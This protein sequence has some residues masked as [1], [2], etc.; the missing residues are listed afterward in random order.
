MQSIM[1]LT[2]PLIGLAFFALSGQGVAASKSDQAKEKRWE[3]QIVPSLLVGEAVKLKAADVEFLGLYTENDTD[4]A[5]GGVILLHGMGAHPAWPSIIDPLR[6][7][8][9]ESGWHTLSLQM[10]ILK[11]E[12]VYKDY[13]P[14]FDE[15]PVRIQAG[16]DYLKAK[17]INNI[18]IIGHSL[19]NTMTTN[20]LATKKDPSVRAFVAIAL[21]P[22][23]PKDPR[24]D[25]YTNF[26]KVTIPTLDIYGSSDS[27]RIIKNARKRKKVAKKAGNKEYQQVKVEGANHFF[28]SMEDVLLQRI[29]GWLKKNAPG[30]E[31]KR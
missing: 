8:L 14:L 30:T 12:A 2:I 11:N 24:T 25:S 4:K 13:L 5:L 28:T 3:A 19:G 23:Y 20:Y 10:P 17:G 22:G 7:S 6:M 29:R 15:V 26:S 21:G 9:P 16:V 31:S 27:D 18:V 1:K